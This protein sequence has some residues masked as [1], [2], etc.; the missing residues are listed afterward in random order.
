MK[1]SL[2]A[3]GGDFA[4]RALI[5]GSLLAAEEIESSIILVGR[6]EDIRA[7][8]SELG[9]KKPESIEIVNSTEVID[10]GE[11]LS[12]AL[13]KRDSSIRVAA[14]LVKS[15]RAEAF[16]SMGHSGAVMAV[17]IITLGKIPGVER[18]AL[19]TLIPT[20]KGTSALIDVG[21]NVDSKPVNLLQF[22]LMGRAFIKAAIEKGNPTVGLLSN[23]EEDIKGNDITKQAH[24]LL[25]NNITNYVGYVEGKDIL[26][27]DVD[28]IVCDGFVGNIILKMGEGFVELLPRFIMKKIEGL[29][30]GE[31]A[32]PSL[33]YMSSLDEFDRLVRENFD[34]NQ[35]GGAPL[36]GI[37]G[38]CILGH[39]RSKATAVK[40][41]IHMA[42]GFA[43]GRLVCE[44]EKEFSK[45]P[46]LGKPVIN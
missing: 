18:P 23:G 20:I 4:P 46:T 12:R 8:M 7:H 35:Y 37:N 13:R 16:V 36:L 11:P 22:A 24:N 17:G 26:L 32:R 34:Y 28:I 39:G 43:K 27:G 33:E 19:A 42:E 45:P 9:A 25:K 15:G 3:M 38:I 30:E 5:E 6:E 10:M 1:I 2:D 44:I 29:S 31:G 41:A 21:A 40:N 14:N